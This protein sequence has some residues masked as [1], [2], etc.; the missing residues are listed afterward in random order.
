MQSRQLSYVAVYTTDIKNIP[1]G[2]EN[3]VADTLSQL[4]PAAL[5]AAATGGRHRRPSGRGSGRESG[6]P[7]LCQDSG[8]PGDLT[9]DLT[10]G[11][12]LFI[13]AAVCGDAGRKGRL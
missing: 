10:G 7:G 12:L 4:P 9:G 1:P 5:P 2:T 3:I 13:A 6:Q 8:E 11:P